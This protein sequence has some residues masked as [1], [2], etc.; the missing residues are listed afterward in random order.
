MENN[1]NDKQVSEQQEKASNKID[2]IKAVK[3]L[4][5]DSKWFITQEILQEVQAGYTV[6]DPN[7]LPPVTQMIEDLKREVEAR[8]SDDPATKE[9]ILDSIPGVPS[10]RSWLKKEGWDDA[11]WK[12]VRTDK[13]FS[14]DK[15]AQVIESLRLRA[16]ER[17]DVAAKI[18]L[19]LSGDYSEK[20]Q[21]DNKT[22]EAYREINSILHSKNDK[23]E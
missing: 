4:S 14:S 21:G 20:E 7:K 5:T 6:I 19:T 9:L 10:V 17:S 16:I 2:A 3:K 22:L 8:Y 13:L 15:R 1:G 12:K 18:W 11:V 23:S